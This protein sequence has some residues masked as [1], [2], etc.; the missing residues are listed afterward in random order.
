MNW[1][2]SDMSRNV[3]HKVFLFFELN[4]RTIN[5]QKQQNKY[6]P[7]HFSLA[8]IIIRSQAG[9]G[10]SHDFGRWV[11]A[12]FMQICMVMHS[13]DICGYVRICHD[14]SQC[15]PSNE[16]PS[17]MI[18]ANLEPQE[19]LKQESR[20]RSFFLAMSSNPGPYGAAS[21]KWWTYSWCSS[22]EQTGTVHVHNHGCHLP[23]LRVSYHACIHKA[24][25]KCTPSKIMRG[26]CR[27]VEWNSETKK[28][29]SSQV[30][31]WLRIFWSSKWIS[32]LLKE[33]E[34]LDLTMVMLLT[35]Q[36]MET[37]AAGLSGQL[38]SNMK[39]KDPQMA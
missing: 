16:F 6:G 24:D 38:A 11:Y 10:C 19:I 25:P 31:C 20:E 35:R 28:D 12:K 2:H 7:A 26:R 23:T 15:P 1:E 4:C 13:V 30:H 21:H 8:S 14:L 34:R 39:P 17:P 22:I 33:N 32:T 36:Y 9:C 3:G 27:S 5:K 29:T 18:R 37:E